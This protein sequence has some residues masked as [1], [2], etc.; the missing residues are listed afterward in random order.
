VVEEPKKPTDREDDQH[1]EELQHKDVRELV[2]KVSTEKVPALAEE[3][4]GEL[5]DVPLVNDEQKNAAKSIF[6]DVFGYAV[7]EKQLKEEDQKEVRRKGDGQLIDEKVKVVGEE[8]QTVKVPAEDEPVR[9]VGFLV[10]S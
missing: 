10:E 5:F 2:A 1:E 7:I 8:T 9:I 6:S 3:V 4:K